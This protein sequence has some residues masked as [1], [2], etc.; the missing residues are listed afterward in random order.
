[1]TLYIYQRIRCLLIVITLITIYL[2]IRKT[3]LNIVVVS[4]LNDVIAYSVVQIVSLHCS[5]SHC[6]FKGADVIPTMHRSNGRTLK[7]CFVITDTD[8]VTI[9]NVLE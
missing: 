9:L 4:T 2:R 3:T 8:F 5:R 1:M 6:P 7:R